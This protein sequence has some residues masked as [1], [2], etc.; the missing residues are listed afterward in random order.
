[1]C[2]NSCQAKNQ[3]GSHEDKP[4]GVGELRNVLDP[5]VLN[6]A[7]TAEL[8]AS[9][10]LIGQQ[11][12]VD[13]MNFGL[14]MQ[15]GGYNIYISGEPG[16]GKTRYAMDSTQRLARD[17]PVPE[18][19]CYVY[20]FEDANTPR[21]INLPAGQGRIF[22]KD[23][24]DFVRVIEQEIIKAF[25]GEDYDAERARIINSSKKRKMHWCWNSLRMQQNVAS[26]CA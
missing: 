17:M 5:A 10:E 7:S 8:E 2:E 24:E 23:M 6:F 1:V 9:R 4:L 15:L 18:D 25:D 12:A 13:A 22:K 16:E 21:A 26:R 11:R 3:G 20:N 14:Q 19:W